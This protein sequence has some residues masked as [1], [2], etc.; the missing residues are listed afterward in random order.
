MFFSTLKADNVLIPEFISDLEVSP[1]VTV[2]N[3]YISLIDNGKFITVWSNHSKIE[4]VSGIRGQLYDSNITKYGEELNISTNASFFQDKPSV[5]MLNDETFLTVWQSFLQDGDGYGIYG[6][7]FSLTQKIGTE[8]IINEYTIG[9]QQNPTVA[10][11]AGYFVVVWQ[12]PDGSENGIYAQIYDNKGNKQGSNFVVNQNLLFD[13]SYPSIDLITQS[14]SKGKT[15][16]FVVTWM[17]YGQYNNSNYDIYAR[18][19]YCNITQTVKFLNGSEFLINNKN[20]GNQTNPKVSL[21]Q[22]GSY[23]NYVIVWEN[24][25]VGKGLFVSNLTGNS[26]EFQINTRKGSLGQEL[27]PSVCF[28]S[29]NYFSVV[30]QIMNDAGTDYDIYAQNFSINGVKQA[31]E[32]LVNTFTTGDQKNPFIKTNIPGN[33]I[34]A[35]IGPNINGQMNS[36]YF[37]PFGVLFLTVATN[38]LS[39]A[40]YEN[41]LPNINQQYFNMTKVRRFNFKISKTSNFIAWIDTNINL[42]I[43]GRKTYTYISSD[44]IQFQNASTSDIGILKN[45]NFLIVWDNLTNGAS[46]NIFARKF[47]E[48]SDFIFQINSLYDAS[49][50]KIV[51]LSNEAFVVVWTC[52]LKNGTTEICARTFTEQKV[53]K[54]QTFLTTNII[55]DV[56]LM[57][58]NASMSRG[59]PSNKI[60][61][62]WVTKYQNYTSIEGRYYSF[63]SSYALQA[64][65]PIFSIYNGTSAFFSYPT[66]AASSN[67]LTTCIIVWDEYD[68]NQ[69]FYNV[70]KS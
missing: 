28:G 62:T 70:R 29:L 60:I 2:G 61:I 63:S 34:I 33:V 64:T 69:G 17:S 21:I 27:Y 50:P 66:V 51:T 58:S 23:F 25:G 49:N 7:Y 36:L 47:N 1:V 5:A 46:S 56:Y 68:V 6:Q 53:P 37:M 52:L 54:N 4:N 35:W 12:G 16:F 38:P 40:K 14:I 59:A 18:E 48:T 19:F 31:T 30:W 11:S 45:N 44:R 41:N 13:Q 32:F 9:D 15:L 65:T 24:Q 22:N 20:E 8:F 39:S 3:P 55:G 67:D 57:K 43:Y 42:L 10:A 26:Q